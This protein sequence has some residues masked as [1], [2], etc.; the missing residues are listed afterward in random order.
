M[1]LSGY[2]VELRAEGT[3]VAVLHGD[4]EYESNGHRFFWTS[5]FQPIQLKAPGQ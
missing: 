4:G 2:D 5:D 3:G 1:A